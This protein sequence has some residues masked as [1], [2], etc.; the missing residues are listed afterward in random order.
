MAPSLKL[1][2]VQAV[3]VWGSSGGMFDRADGTGC[4]MQKIAVMQQVE[5]TGCLTV[6]EIPRNAG[7]TENESLVIC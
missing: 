4:N 3:A 2:E 7:K 5:N 1:S 6:D